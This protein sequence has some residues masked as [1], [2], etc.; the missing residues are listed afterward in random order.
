MMVHWIFMLVALC[1]SAMRLKFDRRS[2]AA[3]AFLLLTLAISWSRAMAQTGVPSA[4]L[5]RATELGPAASIGVLDESRFNA[6]P[7]QSSQSLQ[8]P[9]GGQATPGAPQSGPVTLTLKDALDLAQ[10]NDP[11]FLS[12]L[13]DAAVA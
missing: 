10:K 8:A 2:S 6:G 3:A 11:Q 4:E 5:L 1:W 7:A 13:N 9:A 12:A